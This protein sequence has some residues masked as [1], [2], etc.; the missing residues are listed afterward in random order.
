MLFIIFG[1]GLGLC[2]GV[3]VVDYVDWVGSYEEGI[4]FYCLLFLC[5]FSWLY[6]IVL[7]YYLFDILLFIC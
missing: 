4:A 6:S 2:F 5:F 1:L 7:A 3:A